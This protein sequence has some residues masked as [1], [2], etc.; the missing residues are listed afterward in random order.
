M[1]VSEVGRIATGSCNSEFPLRV[2]HATSGAN[3][4]TCSFS[5][6]KAPRETNMGKYAFYLSRQQRIPT[7]T[8]L[9]LIFWSR[10]S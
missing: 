1:I 8:P 3:P 5:F 10:K 7:F 2:T 4:S 6:S 9:S